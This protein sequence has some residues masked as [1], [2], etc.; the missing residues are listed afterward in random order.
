MFP[1]GKINPKQLKQM[2]QERQNKAVKAQNSE[3]EITK[4]LSFKKK[5]AYA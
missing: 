5:H 2:E 3:K 1:G 4:L